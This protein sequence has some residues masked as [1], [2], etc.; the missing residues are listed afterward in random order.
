MESISLFRKDDVETHSEG[1]GRNALPAVNVKVRHWPQVYDVQAVWPDC[2]E[3][4][5]EQAL[6]FAFEMARQ[7][8][9][10]MFADKETL[11]HYFPHHD[12]K[13]YSEGRQG[14]WL[15]VDGLPDIADWDAILVSAFGRFAVATRREVRYRSSWECVQEAIEAN[16]WYKPLSSQY[17]FCDTD[18]GMI[19]LADARAE[20]LA[21]ATEKYDGAAGSL[22]KQA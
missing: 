22:V 6:T 14:G 13:I 15:V 10:E 7:D 8:F 21:I 4:T 16:Q 20:L 5:A 2:D 12:V 19:V 11:A 18:K 1:Y 17:N 9:W 3:H